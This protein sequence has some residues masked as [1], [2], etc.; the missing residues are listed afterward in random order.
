MDIE[1]EK[2][3]NHYLTNEQRYFIISCKKL[4]KKP[5]EIII[6]FERI[7][8]KSIYHKTISRIWSKYNQT[9]DIIDLKRSGRPSIYSESE[10]EEIKKYVKENP[11]KSNK[12]LA[13][14]DD[15]FGK[16]CHP[17]TMRSVL[18]SLGFVTKHS[19]KKKELNKQHLD[20]RMLFCEN[21][22]KLSVK[23][24][25]NVYWS[26]ESDLFPANM[27]ETYFHLMP[28]EELPPC[29]TKN[30]EMYKVKCWGTMSSDGLGVLVRYDDSMNGEK[31]LKILDENLLDMHPELQNKITRKTDKYFMQD[32]AKCHW[33]PNV[34][35]WF[36]KKNI[37]LINPWPAKSPDLNPIE[38]IWLYIKGELW[39]RRSKIKNK[40]DTWREID[41]IWSNFDFKHIDN[42]YE[43]LPERMEEVIKKKGGRTKY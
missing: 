36:I 8:Q 9:G 38:N 26:D 32:G 1:E 10:K 29:D 35:E 11:R 22:R 16:T 19:N 7:Y 31:Y 18:K 33:T 40:E 28:C 27:S 24:W 23:D 2:I 12:F 25:K 15:L 39:K 3:D 30:Y 21:N 37:K 42:L 5:G 4:G 20:A 17:Q 34:K 6:E 14:S 41:E 13:N 43:S